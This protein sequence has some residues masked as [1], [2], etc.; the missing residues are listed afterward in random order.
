MELLILNCQE[1]LALYQLKNVLRHC[2]KNLM[3][4]AEI[5]L[6]IFVSVS[7][8]DAPVMVKCGSQIQDKIG[9]VLRNGPLHIQCA[10]HTLHLVLMDIFYETYIFEEFSDDEDIKL[11]GH[12]GTG[13]PRDLLPGFKRLIKLVRKY[14]KKFKKAL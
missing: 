3:N 11:E 13:N 7:L 5:K 10:N 9:D 1:L 12:F 14:V 4:L 6:S 8:D 2:I